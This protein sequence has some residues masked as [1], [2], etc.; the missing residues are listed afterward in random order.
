MD[1]SYGIVLFSDH[2]SFVYTQE[3]VGL[4]KEVLLKGRTTHV[5][6]IVCV[7]S[8]KAYCHTIDFN[9]TVALNKLRATL[10]AARL[11]QAED[12]AKLSA[13]WDRLT[14]AKQA[15]RQVD[16][17]A[18]IFG[19]LAS[20]AER[21]ADKLV[22]RHELRFSKQPGQY[23]RDRRTSQVFRRDQN[24]RRRSVAN[25]KCY[26][27]GDV[28]HFARNCHKRRDQQASKKPRTE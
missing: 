27:C 19:C 6:S 16:L 25:E 18:T 28:G 21:E 4:V 22:T 5:A 9:D 26:A 12:T 1:R 23:R 10:D 3:L 7:T 14:F 15:G 8:S 13:L 20:E 2:L 11:S 24:D 17:R